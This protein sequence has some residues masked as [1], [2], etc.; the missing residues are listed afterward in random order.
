M[1]NNIMNTT[2]E[3]A[4]TLDISPSVKISN[5][6]NSPNEW[7]SIGKTFNPKNTPNLSDCVEN[8]EISESIARANPQN[9]P[10]TDRTYSYKGS[11]A[12]DG[13]LPV[14]AIFDAVRHIAH[15]I[16]FSFY[17]KYPRLYRSG[18]EAG[19]M[20]KR[21]LD[22]YVYSVRQ[23]LDLS[24]KGLMVFTTGEEGSPDNVHTHSLAY[25]RDPDPEKLDQ[26]LKA[27]RRLVP[28]DVHS[29]Y[30]ELSEDLHKI[31]S[32]TNKVDSSMPEKEFYAT[33]G[34]FKMV[35]RVKRDLGLMG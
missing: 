15:P 32:Y 4:E 14:S 8:V 24:Q 1:S 7:M 5:I 33:A 28:K 3:T 13:D 18:V 10:M 23:D 9:S 35:A 19:L 20:R 22:D 26:I 17:Y 30:V 31:N 34:Y 29:R 2:I 6:L 11:Q 21:L 12:H 27:M 25:V 16:T